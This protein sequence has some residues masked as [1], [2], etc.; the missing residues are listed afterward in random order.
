MAEL[1]SQT[2]A[3]ALFEAATENNLQGEIKTEIN[4]LSEILSE[5]S[6]YAKILSS[7]IVGLKEK[8]ELANTAF[9]GRIC[10][11]LLN[12]IFVLIDNNRFELFFDVKTEYNR[13]HDR[14]NNIIRVTAVT[15]TELSSAMKDK[16]QSKLCEQSKKDVVLSNEVDETLIG[17]VLLKYDNMEIDG[18]VKT[19]LDE[20]K[21]QVRAK[22]L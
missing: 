3:N 6:D 13:L 19:K 5:N 18:S 10:D 1:V 11:Y 4:A 17:G 21:K 2:Y 14:Q 8:H 12:L 7:P 15:A 22:T 16:L 20:I 9:N